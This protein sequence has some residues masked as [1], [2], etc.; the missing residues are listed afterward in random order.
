MPCPV[1][2]NDVVP[3]RPSRNAVSTSICS[4]VPA[5]RVEVTSLNDSLDLSAR[6]KLPKKRLTPALPETRPSAP[7]STV[8]LGS[9]WTFAPPSCTQVQIG[10]T[11][12]TLAAAFSSPSTPAVR[13]PVR[14]RGEAATSRARTSPIQRRIGGFQRFGSALAAS[15]WGRGGAMAGR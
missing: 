15:R 11:K 9:I 7:N 14:G 4:G 3:S 10:P 1:T 5:R 6:A 12:R 2:W 13:H 8:G